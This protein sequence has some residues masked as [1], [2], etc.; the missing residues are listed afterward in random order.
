MKSNVKD[1]AVIVTGAA[2][3]LGR[4]STLA[5]A[6]AGARVFAVDLN[7][8]GLAETRDLAKGEVATFATNLS[9]ATNCQPVIDKAI[10]QFGY[11][12]GLCNIA[13]ILKVMP[14]AKITPETWDLIFAVNVRAPLFLSQ[15][16]IPHLTGRGGTIVNIASATAFA[17][18]AY[19]AGYTCSKAAIV[20]MTRSLAMEFIKTDLRINAIAPGGVNTPMTESIEFAEGMERELFMRSMGVRP[21]AEAEQL[22]D[23]I[24]YLSSPD[25]TIFHGTC[26][27]TDDGFTAG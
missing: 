15:A 24:L 5:F 21:T 27:N 4:A 7:E 26:L 14:L 22:T 9:D 10:S 3:G 17:G 25:N 13:G 16:A 19:L 12:D 1:R 23:I 6:E 11:L 8:D 20:Q 18:Y 2:S